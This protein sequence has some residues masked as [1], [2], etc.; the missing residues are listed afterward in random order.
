MLRLVRLALL[1]TAIPAVLRPADRPAPAAKAPAAPTVEEGEIDGAKF[2]IARPAVWNHRLLL[3][4]HGLRA[5]SAPL[6]ADLVPGHLAYKT[7]LEE[8]WIVAKTSYRR[9]GA[10]VADAIAD[11]DALRARIAQADGDPERVLIEGESMGGL[12]GTLIAERPPDLDAEGHPLYT[13]VVAIGAALSFREANQSLGLSLQPKI[14]VLFL[15]NQS[16]LEGPEK[17]VHAFVPHDRTDIRP[18]IFRVSRDGHVNVNQRERLAALHALIHWIDEGRQSLPPPPSDTAFFD[19]TVPPAP[20]PSQVERTEDGR[21]FVARITEVS[22]GYGN[23]SLNAQPEDFAA[24]GIR[25]MTW[26]QLKVGEKSFRVRYGRDFDSVKRGEWVAFPDA[27]GFTWLARNLG[28]A[29]ATADVKAGDPMTL[30]R[31]DDPAAATGG[32][33]AP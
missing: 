5:E 16:E 15:T 32:E 22:F 11:L 3:I 33:A 21:G 7:L 17:Y 12:I 13:G 8:G 23:L 20:Q 4:A 6:V 14:P 10:I 9:N 26:F 31:Y 28:N 30:R 1:L 29:A 2:T 25:P 24:A 19:A 18:V 27:D